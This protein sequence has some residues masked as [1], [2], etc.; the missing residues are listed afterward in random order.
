MSKVALVTGA[1]R[2]I[3]RGIALALA[4]RGW[5]VVVNFRGNADAARAT[6]RLIEQA[7]GQGELVQADIAQAADRTR[8]VDETLEAYGRLDLL[9]NNAA[10]A[11]RVRMDMLETS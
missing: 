2:G 1:S 11:P 8:L 4:A 7:D 6:L 3:G 5:V 10:M 9:V